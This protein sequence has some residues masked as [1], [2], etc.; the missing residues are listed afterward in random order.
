MLVSQEQ[1][2]CPLEPRH[3]PVSDPHQW[4]I[5]YPVSAFKIW[6][7]EILRQ[8]QARRVWRRQGYASGRVATSC[9][10]YS[11]LSTE[12]CEGAQ[13]QHFLISHALREP[14]NVLVE[15][16]S[17]RGRNQNRR[18]KIDEN[19]SHWRAT[20]LHR[21]SEVKLNFYRKS[22][23]QTASKYSFTL[24]FGGLS[25]PL[26]LLL[27]LASSRP[28][29]VDSSSPRHAQ[30]HAFTIHDRRY[31][32]LLSRYTAPADDTLASILHFAWVEEALSISRYLSS[33]RH[34]GTC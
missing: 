9:S 13:T 30:S 11:I 14:G 20:H 21:T 6:V 18:T 23:S 17:R 16:A 4:Y 19:A 31:L 24:H 34:R 28:L 27:I 33:Q 10:Q 26:P 12:A 25:V 22:S 1:R 5:D 2:P 29:C 32:N 15:G 7:T 8:V 3:I